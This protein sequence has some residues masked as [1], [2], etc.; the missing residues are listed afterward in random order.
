MWLLQLNTKDKF[1]LPCFKGQKQGSRV[2]DQRKSS[3][4]FLLGF[5]ALVMGVLNIRHV[6]SNS[7]ISHTLSLS[8]PL[9][10][11]SSARQAHLSTPSGIHD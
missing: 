10:S 8:S 3:K 2:R 4:Q 7:C 5:L 9:L 6:F 1:I 11:A